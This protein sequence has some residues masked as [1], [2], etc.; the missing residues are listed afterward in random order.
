MNQPTNPAG[1]KSPNIPS[2]PASPIKTAP[3]PAPAH[4]PKPMGTAAKK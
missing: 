3:A 2:T 1:N 4:T